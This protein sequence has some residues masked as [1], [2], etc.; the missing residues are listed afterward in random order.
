MKP[1]RL[2]E[3]LANGRIAIGHMIM[4][5]GTRGIAQV[6]DG[7]GLD[8]ALVDTEHSGFSHADVADL[9]AWFQATSIAPIVRVPQIQYHLVARTLDA[10]ALGIMAP[11]VK[12]GVQARALVDAAK[13]APLGQRG[14]IVGNANTSYKSV[15]AQEF[16]AYANRT[17]TVICQIESQEGLDNLEE[18]ASTSGVDVLWVGQFDLTQ[19]MGIVGDFGHP[20]FVDALKQVVGTARKHGLA[21][22]IQPGDPALAKEWIAL[23]FNVISCGGDMRLYARALSDYVASVREEAEQQHLPESLST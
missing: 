19:S 17:T 22:G 6:L 23:G 8:F 7:A 11:N 10:G 4:E 15:N 13:Y 2:K 14:V 9:M 18:I 12:N 20:R 5:F 16:L 3:A 1:N 21:A